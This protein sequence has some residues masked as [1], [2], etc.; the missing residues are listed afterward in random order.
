MPKSKNETND[1][2]GVQKLKPADVAEFVAALEAETEEETTTDGETRTVPV[3]IEAPMSTKRRRPTSEGVPE[4]AEVLTPQPPEKMQRLEK[5]KKHFPWGWLIGIVAVLAAA[6]VAG[7]FFFNREKEFGNTNVQLTIKPIA[8]VVSGSTMSI[9]IEYQNLEPIDLARAE[10][11]VE[12]PEGFTYVSS[13]PATTSQYQN[14]FVLG[15]I[16]S[17]QSGSV[18]I[19]GTLLGAVGVSRDFSATLSFTPSNFN[20]VF[21][22]RSTATATIT[23]SILGLTLAGPTQ[24]APNG[25][26]TWTVTYENTSDRDLSNVQLTATYPD[27][28]TV[29]SVTPAAQERSAVWKFSTIKKGAKATLTINGT[30]T[31]SIGDT[32]PLK[33][34]AGLVTSTNTVE[35]QN[36]QTLLVII[37]KTGV[38]TAVVVNGSSDPLTVSPGETLNYSVRVTN[39]SDI[40]LPNTTVTVTLDGVGL[41]ITKLAND[42]KAKVTGNVLTWTKDQLAALAN[43]TPNQAVTLSFAVG[44]KTQ[45]TVAADTDRDPNVRATIAVTSPAL[46]TTTNTAAQPSTVVLTK[47]ST[48]LSL[49]AEAR[50]YNTDGQAVGSGPIPPKVGAT[51]TYRVVWTVTNTS[52]DATSFVVS[53]RLP[54]TTLWTGKNLSRDAGDLVF[55]ADSRTVRWTIN[56]VPA[57]TGGRLSALTASFDI[58]ITPSTDQIGAVPIL[59]ETATATATDSYTGVT[60]TSPASTLTT[61]LPTDTKAVGLGQVVA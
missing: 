3:T 46:V 14:D 20:S 51:T 31:G 27:G 32:L 43:L 1:E 10:L 17:G 7:F 28:L 4:I 22:Q 29:T 30:V 58:S 33:M 15:T 37:V 11:A 13:D 56:T 6:S 36:E 44:T 40:E 47:L 18:T 16:R 45:I 25:A 8:S 19:T 50:Y 55:D 61:E 21:Q 24:L 9:T 35:L 5:S 49:K 60:L 23:S 54:N 26:G 12:Y 41:D 39:A 57:A 2:D 52:S 38:T 42:S 59:I 48:A 34:S 53:A